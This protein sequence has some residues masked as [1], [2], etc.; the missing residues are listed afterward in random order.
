MLVLAVDEPLTLAEK[1][2]ITNFDTFY[3][4]VVDD[5]NKY[6][7]DLPKVEFYIVNL[8]INTLWYARNLELLTCPKIYYQKNNRLEKIECFKFDYIIREFPR[9]AKDSLDLKK[10]LS[11]NS[12]SPP[13]SRFTLCYSCLC[14]N[15]TCLSFCNLCFGVSSKTI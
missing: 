2:L 11:Y 14:S 13:L 6:I 10:R 5:N 15:I 8:K 3:E 4:L 1:K 12:L 7:L 9:E